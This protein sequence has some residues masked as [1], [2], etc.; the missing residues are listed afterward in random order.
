MRRLRICASRLVRPTFFHSAATCLHVPA[1]LTREPGK[2]EGRKPRTSERHVVGCC[3]QLGRPC[4]LRLLPVTLVTSGVRTCI[5]GVMTRTHG[6]L[7]DQCHATE[8]RD[9]RFAL[10]LL[11]ALCTALVLL[12][13]ADERLIRRVQTYNHARKNG[14]VSTESRLLAS[15]ARMWY[16]S[17]TGEG[18]LLTPGRSGSYAHWDALFHSRSMLS[19]W[20]VHGRE[21][22]ATVH[23]TNDFYRLLD[24]QPAPYQMTWW[25]DEQNRIT[26]AMVRS[27]PGKATSRM[28]EF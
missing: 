12:G 1:R 14:D 16:E 24:W 5:T 2:H 7:G 22:T 4:N 13:C 11:T 18:E 17:R 26:G 20:T 28:Q 19:G 23:E 6:A 8:L 3:E 27:L 25:F 21:V 10:S 15:N 9:F